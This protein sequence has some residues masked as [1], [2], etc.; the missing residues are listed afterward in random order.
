M[1]AF[2]WVI[3]I[4]FAMGLLTIIIGGGS[5]KPSVEST[6]A[7]GPATAP[8]PA[9]NKAPEQA[10][11]V[12]QTTAQQLARDY[13]DNE[14]AADEKMK[15][16]V[17]E[18]SGS[19]QSIDKSFTDTI[20]IALRTGNEFMAARMDMDD[21]EKNEAMT[22]KRGAK[23]VIRCERMARIMGSPSGSDCKFKMN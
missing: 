6:A 14:V 19:V 2:K 1:K 11:P 16:K 3:G 15:G 4:F 13:H 20:V 22:L 7:S 12:H 9:Q 5:Q 21:S 17:I 8:P 10:K 18:V 23:V